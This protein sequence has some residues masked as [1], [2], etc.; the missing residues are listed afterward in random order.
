MKTSARAVVIGGGVVGASV[1]YHL[2]KIGWTDVA[3]RREERADLGLDLARGRRHAHLQRRRQHLAPAEVHHRPLPRDRGALGPVLRLHPNG[4]LMLAATEGEI[5]SLKLICSRARYL[6][7]ETEMISLEQAL[8]YNSLIDPR[9]TSSARCGAPMAATAT[10]GRHHPGLREGRRASSAPRSS[11]SPASLALNQRPDGSWDVAHRQ[12]HDPCRA[13]GQ[14]RRPVGAR[15]RPP[16]RHRAAGAGD[17]ASLPVTEDLPELDGRDREIVNTTDYRGRDLHAP[18]AQR[19]PHRHLR[20]ARHRLVA[21]CRRR[22]TSRMQ[23]LP[24]DF[25]RMAP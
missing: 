20:A 18:G 2:A 3:A 7:M 14:L 17:G 8:E 23:L 9:S 12:G 22:T 21:G 13:C 16:G 24:E 10:P 1:L 19:R 5:D 4:G 25:E 6:G 11:A 15:G